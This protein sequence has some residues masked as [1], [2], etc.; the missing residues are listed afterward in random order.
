MIHPLGDRVAV[1]VEQTEEVT[2]SGL[3]I[4]EVAQEKPQRGKVKAVGGGRK[5]DTGERVP[6]DLAVGDIVL[7]SKFGGVEV[8]VNG[9]ELLILSERDVLAI[10]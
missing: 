1:Q 7:F 5:T 8:E 2:A 3:V 6:L 9:E 10:V 4:P